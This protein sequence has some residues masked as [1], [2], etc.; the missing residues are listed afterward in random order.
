MFD[1]YTWVGLPALVFFAR[2]VDVTLGTLRIIFT[3]R[4]KKVLAPLLGFVEVF[5]WVSVIAQITKRADNVAA[6][7]AY[8][9]GFATGNYIGM[10]I[11]NKLAIGM[12]VV[13]AII[14]GSVLELTKTL[15]AK[16]Y[17]VT[18][19]DA[20]GSQGPVNLIYTI[21]QR[22]NLPEVADIIQGEYPN[23]FFTVEELRSVERG[24]FPPP[25]P[26]PQDALF[27]RKT[28]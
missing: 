21:V 24:V 22:K 12:L 15:G 3:S 10:F 16:G 5:I 4:G 14:P 9:A 28:R 6:Y 19:V 23:A 7:F 17:G 27:R 8:A 25:L 2:V 11:E 1:W 18:R 26:S 13:R 20:H